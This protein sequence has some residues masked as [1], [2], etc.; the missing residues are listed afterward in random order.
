MKMTKLAKKGSGARPSHDQSY[1]C[2]GERRRTASG[3]RRDSKLLG[4][5]G[6]GGRGNGGG[7]RTSEGDRD[8]QVGE[9]GRRKNN[10]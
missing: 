7:A 5:K 8:K 2:V 4:G 10:A 3:T 1:Y 6:G 9:G